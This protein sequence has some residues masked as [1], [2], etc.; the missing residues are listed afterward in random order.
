MER[1]IAIFD[2]GM[3]GL[4]V[5]KEIHSL[6]PGKNIIYLGDTARVPYGTKS[7]DVIKGYAKQITKFLSTFNPWVVVV[8]CHT[9]SSLAL[10]FLKRNF[11]QLYFIDV[12]TPSVDESI[13]IT[14]NYRIG[15]IGTP[16][17]ISSGKYQKLIKNANP[18][19]KVFSQPC[20]LFV[21][22]V[23]EGWIK[24]DVPEIIAKKYLSGLINKKIDTIILGCTHYP[25]LKKVIQNVLGRD[26]N[27]I[28]ASEVTGLKVKTFFEKKN[29]LKYEVEK[30]PVLYFT[31]VTKDHKKII[32]FFWKNHKLT[33]RRIT[34]ENHV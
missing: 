21:P 12:V 29:M 13:S 32:N 31:D 2:S 9:V 6:M 1:P 23:E 34:L 27:L 7:S 17:T 11:P 25:I 33:V 16:A 24:G 19:I 4:T 30:S 8:A 28:D 5:V 15:V 26:I 18:G 14:K 22:L 20:P 10:N 3:G